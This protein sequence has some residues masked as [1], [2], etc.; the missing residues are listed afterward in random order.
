MQKY[1][2]RH[3]ILAIFMAFLML[4]TS[5]GI[6]VDMHYCKGE[7]K[8]FSVLGK[9]KSCHQVAQAKQSC[10]QHSHHQQT[11]AIA[12]KTCTKELEQKGCCSNK[13]VVLQVDQDQE[14]NS[15]SIE[16]NKAQECFL[17]AYVSSLL[18]TSNISTDAPSYRTYKPPLITR[19]HPVLFEQFLI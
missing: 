3:N 1:E 5:A 19:D 4:L 7:L 2:A 15:I 16:L 10:S 8:S 12:K 6:A 17:I 14:F 11:P 18:P 9:A 13:T